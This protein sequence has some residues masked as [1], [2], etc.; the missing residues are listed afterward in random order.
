MLL[1]GALS[2]YCA[3]L[4]IELKYTAAKSDDATYSDIAEGVFGPRGVLLVDGLLFFCQIGFCISYVIF[5]LDNLAW[6]LPGIDHHALTIYVCASLILLVLV[7]S[8][9]RSLGLTSTAA[10]LLVFV[11]LFL[12]FAIFDWSFPRAN[13]IAAFQVEGFPLFIGMAIGSVSSI[14]LVLPM[15]SSMHERMG[16]TIRVGKVSAA[17]RRFGHLIWAAV[18]FSSLILLV[19]GLVGSLTFGKEC[20]P[21]ITANLGAQGGS[22]RLIRL[23]LLSSMFLT[24]PLQFLL[25]RNISERYILKDATEQSG[26]GR[27]L[28]RLWRGALIIIICFLATKIPKFALVY[29]FV[30]GFGGCL[31]AFVF[32]LIFYVRLKFPTGLSKLVHFLL[33][34]ISVFGLI[35]STVGSGIELFQ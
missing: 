33:I 17:S 1:T 22:S 21:V 28:V 3:V 35:V 15:E 12:C 2:A 29:S 6:L 14:G 4:M 11:G 32:P 26:G 16:R 34:F 7:F 5:L 27:G 19:F 10:S 30:G 9:S 13:E 20:L 18:I 8:D 23:F 25:V 31:L 24:F